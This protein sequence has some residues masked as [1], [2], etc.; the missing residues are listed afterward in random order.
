LTI[1]GINELHRRIDETLVDPNDIQITS[2]IY[3]SIYGIVKADP[4][5]IQWLNIN[6]VEILTKD[7]MLDQAVKNDAELEIG[8]DWSTLYPV[9]H[10]ASIEDITLTLQE[11][12]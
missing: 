7:F 12:L 3:D 4:E 11:I 10:N 2:T 8:P 1:L 5:L 6:L 9:H